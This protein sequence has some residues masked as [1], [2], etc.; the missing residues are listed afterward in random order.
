MARNSGFKIN[1]K[2]IREM[3]GE[4]QRE[5]DKH[6]VTARVQADPEVSFGDTNVF[7]GP[8]IHGDVRGSQLAWGNSSVSQSQDQSKPIAPGFEAV[9]E[10][11]VDTLRQL[12]TLGVS[13]EELEDASAVGEEILNQ[14]VQP[15]P[16]RGVIRRAVAALKGYLAPIATGAV[17]AGAVTGGEE[18]ARVLIERLSTAL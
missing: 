18:T 12:P 11:V 16:D 9:T 13:D 7:N 6:P 10:A 15:E 3:M 4:I 5:V 17:T 14:V 8:V 2:G 1:K